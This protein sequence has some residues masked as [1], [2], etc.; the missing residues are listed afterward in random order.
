MLTHRNLVANMLQ[1]REAIG[2]HLTDGEEMVIAPLP[3][4]HIYTFTVNC[5]FLMETGNHSLLITNPR[6]LDGF[7]KELKGCPS[8]PLSASTRY[9]MHCVIGTTSSSSIFPS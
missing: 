3:V 9:L 5:L 2:A 6:D 8:L 7:V 1:A 4:Y